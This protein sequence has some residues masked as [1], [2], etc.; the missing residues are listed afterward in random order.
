MRLRSGVLSVFSE[1]GEEEAKEEEEREI[2]H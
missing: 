2:E 1:G